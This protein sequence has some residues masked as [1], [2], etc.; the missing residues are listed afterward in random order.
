MNTYNNTPVVDG[1]HSGTDIANHF[2]NKYN[3]LYNSVTSH[4]TLMDSLRNRIELSVHT[5]CNADSNNYIHYHVITKFDVLKA[6]KKL[7]PDKVNEDGL[8]LSEI[9][10]ND[11]D[12]LFVYVSLLFTVML[13][14]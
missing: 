9:F 7:K 8:L 1:I 4:N 11:S 12:L 5:N 6:V 2:K 13:S 3:T 10:I 14:T